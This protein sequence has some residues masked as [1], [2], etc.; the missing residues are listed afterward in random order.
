MEEK[1]PPFLKKQVEQQQNNEEVF[2]KL[3]ADKIK[4]LSNP[5]RRT[6]VLAV[7]K[8]SDGKYYYGENQ[9]QCLVDLQDYL[10][11][12][13]IKDMVVHAEM[14]A[15]MKVPANVTIEECYTTFDPCLS[16][17]KHLVYRGCKNFYTLKRASKDW[18]SPEREIFIKH[19]I[20]GGL[21]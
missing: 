4:S 11:R 7:L 14:V 9:D 15:L 13:N 5:E 1:I 17:L 19:Y 10:D 16:C 6:H 21:H 20:P 18:N 12:Y 2:A 8:G 3:L